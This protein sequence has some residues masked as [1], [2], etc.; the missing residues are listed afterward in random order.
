MLSTGRKHGR[1]LRA[2]CCA[3]GLW[4]LLALAADAWGQEQPPDGMTILRVEIKGLKA[5]SEGYV[6]RIIK[7][8]ED[9]PFALRQVEDDV[10]E[11]LRSRK[12]LGA[13]ASTSVEDNQAVVVFNVQE[14]PAIASVEVE[15]NK[16]FTDKELYELTPAAGA[17]LDIY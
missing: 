4:T 6:R 14:K 5:I 11:L 3:G 2:A 10:R 13:F 15:G 12:F 7:T 17:V 8:R 1:L 16:K 9:T